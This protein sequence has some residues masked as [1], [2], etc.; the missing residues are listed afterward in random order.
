MIRDFI[1]G[2]S[3]RCGI[4]LIL[5]GWFRIF[6]MRLRFRSFI[7]IRI[8]LAHSEIFQ[9]LTLVSENFF[10]DH[11]RILIDDAMLHLV[12]LAIAKSNAKD[13]G[14][15]SRPFVS[16]LALIASSCSYADV[17]SRASAVSLDALRISS[18]VASSFASFFWMTTRTSVT[19]PSGIYQSRLTS[20]WRSCGRR[21]S[22]IRPSNWPVTCSSRIWCSSHCPAG[23]WMKLL[24]RSRIWY[25]DWVNWV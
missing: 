16:H 25:I 22:R 14:V 9:H 6:M 23:S 3:D 24:K 11:V 4:K 5:K 7:S 15:D 10:G 21:Q 18:S 13:R 2:S 19:Q 1:R 17:N 12:E 20:F 8:D